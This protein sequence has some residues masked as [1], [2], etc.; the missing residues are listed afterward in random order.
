MKCLLLTA[1]ACA[2]WA[3]DDAN[4]TADPPIVL[5]DGLL[6]DAA[7][8][9]ADPPDEGVADQ[10]VD[11]AMDAAPDMA[12]ADMGPIFTVNCDA[13]PD[14]VVDV[15]DLGVITLGQPMVFGVP[16]EVPDDAISLTIVMVEEQDQALM[17]VTQLVD[18]TG[19]SWVSPMPEGYTPSAVDRLLGPFP[20]G[21]Y[22]PNRSTAS[23]SG[24][25]A[26]LVPN[27]PA[28]QVMPGEWSVLFSAASIATG[29]P[30]QTEARV[31]VLI[32]RAARLPTCG[33]L[34]LHLYFTGAR[35]WTAE[36][37]PDDAD[38]QRALERM[39][40]FYAG[41]GITLDPVTYDDVPDPPE[42]VDATGGPNSGM[43]QLFAQNDYEDGV[44]LFFVSRLTSPFGGG[45]G[46]VSG[47]IPGPSLQANT[48]RSG[49]V[50]ATELDP[51]PD[52]IGHIMG[53]ESGHY[54]GLFHTIEFIGL[55]DQIDDTSPSQRDQSNLMFP[56]VTSGEAS[57]SPGQ[58]WVLHH[59]ASVIA[60]VP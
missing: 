17:V 8:V 9:D 59:N 3:C 40:A 42:E 2:L 1:L 52:A 54:L 35:G 57:L 11:M 31:Q 15:V 47:G 44:A 49:V 39:R 29:Q 56:T 46:G 33:R 60:E 7:P 41:V 27:N 18:P 36:T 38:F 12:P 13:V 30:V 26:L 16:F 4:P 20:G 6:A 58:G 28:V 50:V 22:S 34:P 24:A 51:D 21:F 48:P 43:H 37:A 14:V 45:V 5:P 32:K 10:S 19:T 55:Q 25:G 23:A 53:H